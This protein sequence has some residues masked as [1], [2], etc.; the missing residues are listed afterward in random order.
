MNRAEA[1]KPRI[2][3]RAPH[4]LSYQRNREFR[5]HCHVQLKQTGANALHQP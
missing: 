1:H 3:A 4:V 5:M 2:P